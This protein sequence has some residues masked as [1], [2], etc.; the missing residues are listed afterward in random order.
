M[1]VIVNFHPSVLKYF[2]DLIDTLFYENY[3]LY[4]DSAVEYVAKL[5][6]YVENQIHKKKHNLCPLL[7]SVHGNYFVSFN[8]N[9][10]TTWYFVFDKIDNRYLITYVFN[11]YSKE[12]KKIN[13]NL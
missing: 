5:I 1:E 12:A 9:A 10:K 2:N 11:N 8:L 7:V 3:F 6:F 4:R 13:Q